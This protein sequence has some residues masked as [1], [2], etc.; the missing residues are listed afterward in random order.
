MSCIV[1][2]TGIQRSFDESVI[3]TARGLVDGFEKGIA[4]PALSAELPP[5]LDVADQVRQWTMVGTG[6]IARC[7]AL[8]E[9]GC[10]AC[11]APGCVRCELAAELR[12]NEERIY[13]ERATELDALDPPVPREVRLGRFIDGAVDQ[14]VKELCAAHE[15][16]GPALAREWYT[17]RKP[18]PL[19][20]SR[21]SE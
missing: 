19:I 9:S 5:T 1:C 12:A 7:A 13:T 15:A 10:S 14:I 8:V 6:V 20:A 11:G 18:T 17:R 16:L 3:M 4:S 21:G 2:Q